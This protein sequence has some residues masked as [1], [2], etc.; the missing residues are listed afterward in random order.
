MAEQAKSTL[1]A[2]R[3]KCECGAYIYELAMPRVKTSWC[4]CSPCH[5]KFK[6]WQ[7]LRAQDLRFLKGDPANLTDDNSGRELF[8]HKFCPRCGIAVMHQTGVNAQS[9]QNGQYSDFQLRDSEID[10]FSGDC[11]DSDCPDS[12]C[13]DCV[14]SDDECSDSDSIMAV[15]GNPEDISMNPRAAIEEGK[16]SSSC[17]C[18]S[19]RVALKLRPLD[20]AYSKGICGGCSYCS[21]FTADWDYLQRLGV[22]LKGSENLTDFDVATHNID[23]ASC[24][25]CSVTLSSRLVLVT[26]EFLAMLPKEARKAFDGME[27]GQLPIPRPT[28]SSDIR[29]VVTRKINEFHELNFALAVH[30]LMF[31]FLCLL[32]IYTYERNIEP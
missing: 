27:L 3:G 25:H 21:R 17:S 28:N 7:V 22:A 29:G 24:R 2:Y 30:I 32:R 12:D 19:V 10:N 18:G 31:I 11:Y 14:W 16:L 15:H 1:K 4:K 5:M 20:M 6:M 23:K 13:S 26:D 8:R 9:F